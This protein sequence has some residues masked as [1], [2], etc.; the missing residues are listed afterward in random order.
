MAFYDYINESVD[1]SFFLE[2]TIESYMI[3]D[4]IYP[5]VEAILKTP[6]GDRRFRKIIGEFI[7]RNNK[8]LHTAGPQY[9]I[10][11]TDRDKQNYYDLFKLEPTKIKK[12]LKE[13][14]NL[15]NNQASWRLILDNPIYT[16]FFCV[17]RYYA[18]AKDS[19]GLNLSLAAMALAMYPSMFHKYFPYEPNPEIMRYTI[20]NLSNKFIIK[21]TNH[22]F[23]LLMA[24]IQQCFKFHEKMIAEGSDASCVN[25]I[26]RIRNAYNSSMKK[27]ASEF[28][29]NHKKNLTVHTSVDSFDDNAVVD[30]ENDTNK[31]SLATINII[32]SLLTSG[33]D[34][35]LAEAAARGSQVSISDI[36]NYLHII[37][38]ESHV[39]EMSSL[40]ES[41]IFLFLYQM[42]KN[43][44]DINSRA[45]LEFGL[46]LYKKTN[47]NDENIVNIKNILDKWSQIVGLNKSF[48]RVATLINY[49]RALYM[50]F[51]L[52]IQKYN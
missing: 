52:A 25:Y 15:V 38:Q 4:S 41:I 23:G 17:N 29:E 26:M 24:T 42:K 43:I 20:D 39:D 51:I 27:I 31:V 19:A 11:F 33:V 47:S 40:I 28:H 18:K 48:S 2:A 7:D 49:K 6:E 5:V 37:V 1:D 3:R 32:N 9:M 45:F 44:R 46:A 35:R 36:R 30:V 21:K 50:F 12:T 8:K 10:A 16:V 34:V 14:L 22:V 13:A